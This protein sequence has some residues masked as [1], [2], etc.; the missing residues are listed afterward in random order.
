MKSAH[1]E[2]NYRRLEQLSAA[3]GIPMP[4]VWLTFET[5]DKH[6]IITR[7]RVRSHTWTRNMWNN[8][9]GFFSNNSA[10]ATNFGAGHLSIK[11]SS[12]TVAANP[13]G[14][15]WGGI[16]PV[17][18]VANSLYGIVVGAGSTAWTFEDYTLADL[19]AHGTGAGQLSYQPQNSTTIAYDNGSLKWG[20]Q[21]QRVFSNSSGGDITVYEV[22]IRIY[23]SAA[24]IYYMLSRDVLATPVLVAD[25]AQLTV[26]YTIVLTFPT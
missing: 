11:Q 17:G 21:L 1:T 13:A 15:Q 25:G 26:T 19:I 6:G 9:L 3:L 20:A 23:A 24:G 16:N 10:E 2:A 12:G 5:H 14:N 22:G 8:V 18:L 4:T 7:H